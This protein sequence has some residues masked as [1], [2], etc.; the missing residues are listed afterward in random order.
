LIGQISECSPDEI[1]TN[2]GSLDEGNFSDAYVPVEPLFDMDGS[3]YH[4]PAP[5]ADTL[6]DFIQDDPETAAEK[7]I[8]VMNASQ[9]LQAR[10]DLADQSDELPDILTPAIPDFANWDSQ[11]L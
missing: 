6:G 9:L 5:E 2:D 8:R 11:K 3:Y 10:K 1:G 4:A 7:F